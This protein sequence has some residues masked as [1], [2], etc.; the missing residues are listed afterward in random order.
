M[1]M[2]MCENCLCWYTGGTI[3]SELFALS[4]L[5]ELWLHE[6]SLGIVLYSRVVR[7]GI[8]MKRRIIRSNCVHAMDDMSMC[9]G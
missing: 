4:D 5:T 6:N 1:Y 8:G 7:D 2:Q 3:P 9:D